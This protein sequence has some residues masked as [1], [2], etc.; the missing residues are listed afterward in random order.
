MLCSASDDGELQ[1]RL[2]YL[3]SLF[4]VWY[5][6]HNMSLG[7]KVCRHLLEVCPVMEPAGSSETSSPLCHM[8]EDHSPNICHLKNLTFPVFIVVVSK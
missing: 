8:S 1:L 4:T 6:E 5:P 2:L 7:R 3:Q